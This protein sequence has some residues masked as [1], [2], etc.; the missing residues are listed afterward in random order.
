[1]PPSLACHTRY[2]LARIARHFSNSLNDWYNWLCEI[3]NNEL[4]K[5][6]T[7]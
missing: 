2:P 5:Y 1:M 4:I 3:N 6:Y 7:K